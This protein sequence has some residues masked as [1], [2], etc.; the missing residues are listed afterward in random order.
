MPALSSLIS[1]SPE[2]KIARTSFDHV[3]TL[4]KAGMVRADLVREFFRVQP[5][6]LDEI[7]QHFRTRYEAA[8]QM[9]LS[10]DRIF[11]ELQRYAGGEGVPDVARQSGVLAVLAFFF[12]E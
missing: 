8:R 12:E 2:D 4:L 7:A 6:R 3:A 5:N 9:G 10:P 1:G 11:V